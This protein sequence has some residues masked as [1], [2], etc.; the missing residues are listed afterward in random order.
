MS[1]IEEKE[2][3][4]LQRELIDK[5]LDYQIKYGIDSITWNINI[6]LVKKEV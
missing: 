5:I 2:I 4:K 3:I 6:H 1:V